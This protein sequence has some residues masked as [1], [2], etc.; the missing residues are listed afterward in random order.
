MTPRSVM[1]TRWEQMRE[2]VFAA[3][4]LISERDFW[5]GDRDR[6]VKHPSALVR[7]F[8]RSMHLFNDPCVVFLA[9]YMFKRQEAASLEKPRRVISLER[10]LQRATEND[11][12]SED[13]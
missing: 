5:H 4:G 7:I 13:E 1:R 2:R 8:S 11:L 3:R 6:K 9:F 10:D 12:A